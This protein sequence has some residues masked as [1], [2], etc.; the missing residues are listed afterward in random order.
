M[1]VLPGIGGEGG[2]RF[3]VLSASEARRKE[4]QEGRLGSLLWAVLGYVVVVVGRFTFF[5]ECRCTVE[6]FNT[7]I[8]QF[9]DFLLY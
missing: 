3:A 9:G 7:P 4:V 8:N 1:H 5:L 2:V 6:R